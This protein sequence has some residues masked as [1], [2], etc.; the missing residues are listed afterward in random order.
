M[1]SLSYPEHT[2]NQ[3]VKFLIKFVKIKKPGSK[4]LMKIC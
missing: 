2:F 3:S 1:V 4:Y